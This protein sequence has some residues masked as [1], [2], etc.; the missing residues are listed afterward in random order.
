MSGVM[1]IGYLPPQLLEPYDVKEIPSFNMP[2]LSAPLSRTL[3]AMGFSPNNEYLF[4]RIIGTAWCIVAGPLWALSCY[5]VPKVRR[6]S[7]GS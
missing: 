2:K 5:V 1:G 4:C 3:D 6:I 7:P